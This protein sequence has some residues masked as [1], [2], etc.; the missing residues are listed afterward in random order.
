MSQ[1]DTPPHPPNKRPLIVVD[2]RLQHDQQ[3]H[4]RLIPVLPRL[5]TD[6]TLSPVENDPN[7]NP[8]DNSNAWRCRN[9]LVWNYPIRAKCFKCLQ[10]RLVSDRLPL[11]FHQIQPNPLN[12]S[13]AWYCRFCTCWN[14]GWRNTC[15]KINCRQSP[16][17]FYY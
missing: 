6:S 15:W 11:L 1:D 5:P 14:Y 2:P 4:L 9:C 3:P 17:N 13:N 16:T 10:S 12:D 7:P 8:T